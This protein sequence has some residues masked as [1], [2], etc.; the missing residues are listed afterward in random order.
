MSVYTVIKHHLTGCSDLTTES[1]AE[2]FTFYCRGT[3]QW[4]SHVVIG[5]DDDRITPEQLEQFAIEER[6]AAADRSPL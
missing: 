2:A 4:V 5:R 1:A 6:R 3:A